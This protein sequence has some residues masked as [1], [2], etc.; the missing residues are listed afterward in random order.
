MVTV[1]ALAAHPSLSVRSVHRSSGCGALIKAP[2]ATLIAA[3]VT[4]YGASLVLE[5]IALAVLRKREP[6]LARP[7]RVPGGM[8]GAIALGVAPA[9]LIIYAIVASRGERM[10]SHSALLCCGAIAAAG[11]V[12]F[13][14]ARWMR[15]RRA[16]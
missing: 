13:A 4:L 3:D 12:V 6:G 9:A 7:F 10:G 1:D 16:A 5:F 8:A 2:T 11:P 14:V 15:T